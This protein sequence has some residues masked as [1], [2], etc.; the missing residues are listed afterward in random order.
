[1]PSGRPHLTRDDWISIAWFLAFVFGGGAILVF[2]T[3][4]LWRAVARVITGHV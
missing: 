3:E 2:V 1:M 4:Q